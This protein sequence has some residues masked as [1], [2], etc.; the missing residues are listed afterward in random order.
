MSWQNKHLQ[1]SDREFIVLIYFKT[2]TNQTLI[3]L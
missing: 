1:Y 2:Y 3:P